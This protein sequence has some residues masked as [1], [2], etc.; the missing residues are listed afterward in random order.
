MGESRGVCIVVLHVE[1]AD[2]ALLLQFQVCLHSNSL[3]RL[4]QSPACPGVHRGLKLVDCYSVEKQR[5]P[6]ELESVYFG[7]SEG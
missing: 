5:G 4:V 2:P 1:G 6:D 3:Q 7:V